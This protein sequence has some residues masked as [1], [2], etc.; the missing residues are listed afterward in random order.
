MAANLNAI[1]ARTVSGK[2]GEQRG[3]YAPTV[4][5]EP[6]ALSFARLKEKQRRIRRGAFPRT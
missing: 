2:R 3:C 1:V 6:S 4:D 5:A